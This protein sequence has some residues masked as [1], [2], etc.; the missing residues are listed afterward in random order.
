M[1]A[2]FRKSEQIAVHGPTKV[3]DRPVHTSAA[4]ILSGFFARP[5][6]DQVV[7]R[8]AVFAATD[9][10]HP[11]AIRR[12]MDIAEGAARSECLSHR[13]GRFAVA[14]GSIRETKG[15]NALG[16]L[17]RL[18]VIRGAKDQASSRGI[19]HNFADIPFRF[20]KCFCF[21]GVESEQPE[22]GMFIFFIHYVSVVFVFFLFFFCFR[23]CVGSKE[24][25]LLAVGRP[26][27]I[28]HATFSFGKSGSFAA[29]RTHGVNLLLFVAVGK[30]SQLFPVRRP[31]RQ[32]FGLGGKGELPD[33]AGLF[34]INP[35]VARA[36]LSPRR[37]RDHKRQSAAVWRKLQVRNIAQV[38]GGFWS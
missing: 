12:D 1:E 31:A 29:G 25:D 4:E 8:G 11:F 28:L 38:Q 16:V 9:K 34:L 20:G 15:K 36:A 3:K 23:F 22:P 14:S 19:P 5:S 10:C 27:K 35:N 17:V 6:E 21:S 33:R 13:F 7:R 37:L 26:G 30:K 32:E 2:I 24:G 18:R